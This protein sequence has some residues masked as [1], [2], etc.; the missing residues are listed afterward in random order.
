[1]QKYPDITEFFCNIELHKVNITSLVPALVNMCLRYRKLFDDD[2]IESLQYVMVGG[3]MFRRD[4]AIDLEKYFNCTVVQVFGMSEGMTFITELDADENI[5]FN[6]QGK[7]ASQYDEFRIVNNAGE[8]VTVGECGEIIVRGPYT[9]TGYYNNEAANEKSFNKEGYYL[10]GDKAV[11][12][13]EGN[14]RILG[15]IREQI[16]RAGEK[17]MPS[18]LEEWISKC[19]C[20]E[21]CSVLGVPDDVLGNK[22]CVFAVVNKAL[23]L[24]NLRE[25]LKKEN[26]SDFYLPDMLRVVDQLPLTPVGKVDKNEL[27]HM[28]YT[29]KEG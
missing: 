6:Y 10:T 9:I 17:I 22:I 12:E 16:N 2:N 3:A 5:R 29:T 1:M 26:V 18:A 25:F 14:V 11:C 21:Q 24:E 28:V 7:P 23:S 20:V 13:P 8:D 4:E 15:R 19:E 27:L